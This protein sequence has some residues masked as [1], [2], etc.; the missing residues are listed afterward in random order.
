M[1]EWQSL[2]MCGGMQVPR[3]ILPKV[4]PNLLRRLRHCIGPDLRE[5]VPTTRSRLAGRHAMPD[6]FTVPEGI[7]QY[8]VAHTIGS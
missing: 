4:P 6:H 3:V 8:S 7:R 2:P 1:H 5:F